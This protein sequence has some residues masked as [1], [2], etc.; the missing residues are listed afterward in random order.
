MQ[1]ITEIGKNNILSAFRN[2]IITTMDFTAESEATENAKNEI[3]YAIFND[4]KTELTIK[5]KEKLINAYEGY[6]V[7]FVCPRTQLNKTLNENNIIFFIEGVI[8]NG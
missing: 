4:I 5:Q 2:L 3:F 8:N 1:K 7:A 6:I